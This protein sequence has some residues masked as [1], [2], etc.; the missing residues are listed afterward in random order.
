MAKK[1]LWIQDAV[2]PKREGKYRE[3]VRRRYGKKGFTQRGTI[4][5]EVI[6]KDVKKKGKV[7]K[8]ARLAKTLKGLGKKKKRKRKRKRKGR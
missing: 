4:K 5:Q 6:A 2:K 3:S 1:E 7:G 8:Q